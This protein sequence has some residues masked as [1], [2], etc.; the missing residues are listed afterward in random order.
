MGL[1]SPS[2]NSKNLHSFYSIKTKTT[3]TAIMPKGSG[4]TKP[5]KL[6]A[7][8]ADIVGKKE[9]SRAECI[10]Q[11]WAYIKKNNLQ[12]PENKQFFT[13]DKKMA[14]VF[15]SDRIRAFG[16]AKFLSSHLQGQTGDLYSYG[17]LRT[18]SVF[19]NYSSITYTT[20]KFNT[21]RLKFYLLNTFNAFIVDIC[22]YSYSN[23]VVKTRFY[24]SMAIELLLFD[25][26]RNSLL[27]N[28]I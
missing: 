18:C 11:L 8:L 28:K 17:S 26:Q 16:M 22:L 23:C 12:D 13:P 6:S 4:L 27:N 20:Q 7:D 5:M 1:R 3:K 15:G 9:A 24:K 2:H 25:Q 19:S 14:K 10:K 21:A